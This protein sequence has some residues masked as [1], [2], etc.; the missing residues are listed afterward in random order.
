MQVSKKA[1]RSA[2]RARRSFLFTPRVILLFISICISLLLR[3]DLALSMSRA[4]TNPA[5]ASATLVSNGADR[6]DGDAE[7]TPQTFDFSTPTSPTI[8]L[9]PL[10]A[11]YYADHSGKTSLG[12]PVTVAFSTGQ[13]W[14]QFFRTGALLLPAVQRNYTDDAEDPLSE[15][16]DPALRDPDSGI[17]RLSLIQALLTAGSQAPLGGVGSP[18]TYLDLRKATSPNLMRLAPPAKRTTVSPFA[19]NQAI[20]VKGGTRGR[21]DVGHLVPLAIWNYIQRPDVSPDGWEEDFGPP[22][23]EALAFSVTRNGIVHHMLAQVFWQDGVVLD[24]S[25][26]NASGQPRVQRL[27]SGI[28]YLSTIGPPPAVP[29]LQQP[30]W[31]Q[32][33]A[34]L[35]DGPGTGHEVAHLGQNF[36]LTLLGDANWQAGQ[37]W[38]HIQWGVPGHTYTGWAPATAI[39]FTSPGDV[40]GWAS[41]DALSPDL[42]AY[43]ASFGSNA[44]AVVYDVTR[45][46]YYTY[47]PDAQFIVASSMKVPIMVTFFDM[48][49]QEGREPDDAEMSLLTTM[50]ENSNNDSAETL[51]LQEGN[52]PAVANYMSRIGITGLNPYPGAFGWSVISSRAMVNLLTLLYEGKILT[53]GDRATA[54]NLMENIESDQQVGVGDTAPAGATVAMKDGWVPGPDGL[55]AMNTSGIVTMGQETYIISVYTQDLDSLPDEQ[56]VTEHI[57][58]NVASLLL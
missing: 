16:M 46:R 23:T 38:Y 18:L 15:A 21:K 6:W 30:A 51:Y 49:E 31:V 52:A 54:L 17:L 28:D 29:D 37:L 53:A 44:G 32:A 55:W 10:F 13:G 50:I 20:F 24:M 27:E 48:T 35:L 33:A 41:M 5:S 1:G 26:L 34:T 9:S 40:A 56:A 3:S 14:L 22:L 25:A 47:D 2:K 4:V 58:G 7:T 36:P 45:G 42:G 43:L 57:C 12:D 39:T 8:S 11:S 19:A